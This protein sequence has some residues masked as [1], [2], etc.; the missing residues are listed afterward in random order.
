MD[1]VHVDAF[2][3]ADIGR[4]QDVARG[5]ELGVQRQVASLAGHQAHVG[6]GRGADPRQLRHLGARPGVAAVEKSADQV[7]LH[8]DGGQAKAK[9][10]VG[11]P[12]D[13]QPLAKRGL[14]G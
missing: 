11:V 9:E 3:D 1:Q 10:I 13:P 14:A 5:C 2:P 12:R 4:D 8:R 6:P 7:G